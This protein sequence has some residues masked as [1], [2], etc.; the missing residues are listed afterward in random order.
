MDTP[1]HVFAKYVEHCGGI[2][3]AAKRL[4]M[5]VSMASL[6]RAGKRQ[7]TPHV[8]AKVEQDTNGM[9]RKESLI[10]WDAA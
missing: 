1:A 9:L 8:A 7:I 5:S 6:I 2:T 10:N 3:A 4:D